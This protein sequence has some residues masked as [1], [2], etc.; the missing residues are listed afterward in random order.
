MTDHRKIDH[1][2][3]VFFD[4]DDTLIDHAECEHQALMY[5]FCNIGIDYEES[6]RDVF[7]QIEKELWDDPNCPIPKDEIFVYRF[8]RLFELIGVEY[9]N[10][11]RANEL[12]KEG[13]SQTNAV[14]ERAEE[15]VEYVCSKKLP[16]CIVTNGLVELQKPRV[17]NS[18]VGKYIDHI[19]AS[20]EARASKPDPLIFNLMLQKLDMVPNDVIMIGDSLANDIQGAKNAGIKSVWFNPQRTE[21]KTDILPDYEIHDLREI[22]EII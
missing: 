21:N 8:C 13:L 9:D 5:M 4:A 15:V 22:K 17:L 7:R 14:L 12:F 19:M 3:A 20:E 6:Y 16:V 18:A 11:L 1:L 2:K 10:S